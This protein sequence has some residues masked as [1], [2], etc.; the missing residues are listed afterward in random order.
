MKSDLGDSQ[1]T[2]FILCQMERQS[3]IIAGAMMWGSWGKDLA[4]SE[5]TSLIETLADMGVYRYD[6]ADIYGGYTT[7]ATWGEAYKQTSI[8]RDQVEIISKCSIMLPCAARP[9][10]TSKHYDH[11]REH[12]IASACRSIEDLRCD[13]LDILLIHRPGPLMRYEEMASAMDYLY[14]EGLVRSFGVSNFSEQQLR[15][16]HSAYPLVAQQIEIS[17]AH[18]IPMI[19]GQ[20]DVCSSLDI[21]CMAWSPLA[22]GRLFVTGDPLL[23]RLQ[24]LAAKVGLGV[25]ELA[26]HF[27]SHHPAE[28]STVVGS[29]T[30]SRIDTAIK[31]QSRKIDDALWYEIYTAAMG[32]EVP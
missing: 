17:V 9:E 32:H 18:H 4:V 13:Y 1:I 8:L 5:M 2:L 19:D 30:P 24:S 27:I 28:I 3:R 11:S 7:E 21:E 10:I 26:Y 20:I 25:D 12:I 14:S 29:T 23:D 16:M 6:H 15:D 31:C 22:N